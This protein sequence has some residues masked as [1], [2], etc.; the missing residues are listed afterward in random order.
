MPGF[1]TKNDLDVINDIITRLQDLEPGQS[2]IQSFLK[3][4]LD[5]QQPLHISLSAPL[6]LRTEQKDAFQ[7]A[8]T[9]AVKASE[10]RKFRVTP[11]TVEW[12]PNMERSRYFLVLKLTK[13]VNDDLN[14]LLAACNACVKAW[15]M[16][17]LY[18]NSGSDHGGETSS[19]TQK[20]GQDESSAFHVSIAWTLGKPSDAQQTML[21]GKAYDQLRGIGTDFACVKIKVGNVVT[22]VPL[23]DR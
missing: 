6:V 17:P 16:N 1:P 9:R 11:T 5:V 18:T 21:E 19:Q 3:S 12:V 23:P 14:K 2:S 4:N 22:D 20:L 7:D 15:G 8:V 10:A 13:P